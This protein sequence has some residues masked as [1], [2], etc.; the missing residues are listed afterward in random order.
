MRPAP[1]GAHSARLQQSWGTQL[2]AWS[3]SLLHSGPRGTAPSP[4]AGTTNAAAATPTSTTSDRHSSPSIA[5]GAA[6]TAMCR[7]A[8]ASGGPPAPVGPSSFAIRSSSGGARLG[9]LT[10]PHGDIQTPASLLYT[11][12][13]SP[14]HLVPD[15]VDKLRERGQVL[16]LNAMHLCALLPLLLLLLPCDE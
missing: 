2:R 4:I 9:V 5:S 14:M 15:T 3:A 12:Q 1:G 10:T 13:G 8:E 11:R 6:A 16:Q 7:T